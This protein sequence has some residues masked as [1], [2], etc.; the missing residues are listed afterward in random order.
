M[1]QVIGWVVFAL[2]LSWAVCTNIALRQHYV[3]VND[4]IKSSF[5][6]I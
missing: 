2:A 3:W 6:G 5:L 1:V 4:E